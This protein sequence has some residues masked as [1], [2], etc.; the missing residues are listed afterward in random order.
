MPRPPPSLQ[1]APTYVCIYCRVSPSIDLL[2]QRRRRPKRKCSQWKSRKRKK[3]T[4]KHWRKSKAKFHIRCKSAV[5]CFTPPPPS[6]WTRPSCQTISATTLGYQGVPAPL[7]PALAGEVHVLVKH[8][9]NVALAASEQ[10][11][12]SRSVWDL[13]G[14]DMYDFVTL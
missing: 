11:G 10:C 12:Q 4:K 1:W 8:K 2:L 13:L 3:D 9:N 7:F 5:S 14:T 6:D